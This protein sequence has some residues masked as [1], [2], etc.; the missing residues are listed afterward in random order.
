MDAVMAA[1][2]EG[3]RRVARRQGELRAGREVRLALAIAP[4]KCLLASARGSEGIDN[5]DVRIM[6]GTTVLAQDASADETAEARFCAG[7]ERVRV[8]VITSSIASGGEFA[9]A[10]FTVENTNPPVTVPAE[11]TRSERVA[12]MQAEHA[13]GHRPA[14]PPTRVTLTAEAPSEHGIL[15]RAG[16]CYRIFVAGTG[17]MHAVVRAPSGGLIQE[18]RAE[19]GAILGVHRPLCAAEQGRYLLTLTAAEAGTA[20]YR[21]FGAAPGAQ[22]A[23]ATEAAPAVTAHRVGGEGESYVA[24]QLRASH[25]Q[26]GVGFAA[27]TE[28]RVVTLSRSEVDEQ[29]VSVVRERCYVALASAAP[30]ARSLSIQVLDG[31]GH[32]VGANTG[33]LPHV[34]FCAEAAGTFTVKVKMENGYGETGSQVFGQ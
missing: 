13:P 31:F 9:L 18:Q 17:A 6:A 8:R 23:P 11:G 30:S 24:R 22:T 10:A 12:A 34:R 27:I 21:V 16:L 32:E 3:A 29:S 19:N 4:G 1:A 25:R 5:L 20:V 7:E 28:A 2:P 33:A 15:L 14:S 26:Q